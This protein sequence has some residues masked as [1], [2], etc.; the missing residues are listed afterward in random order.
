MQ[1]NK[2]LEMITDVTGI[3]YSPA[4]TDPETALKDMGISSIL[5]VQ[6]ILLIEEELHCEIEEELL[7]LK[8]DPTLND[9]LK[10]VK[11]NKNV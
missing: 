10:I 2:I 3:Q 7:F 4:S 9:I 1:L 11:N 8:A 6:L 5:F